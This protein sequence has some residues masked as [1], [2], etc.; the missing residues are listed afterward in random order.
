MPVRLME[1]KPRGRTPAQ[2]GDGFA[3][4]VCSNSLRGDDLSQ[5]VGLL[6]EEMRLLGSLIL[7]SADRSRVPAGGALAVD[8]DRFSNMVTSALRSHPMIDVRCSEVTSIPEGPCVLATGPLTGDAL[9]SDLARYV[10]GHLAYYDAIA[11]VVWAES[12]DDSLVFRAS[13]Y[14]KGGGDDYINCPMDEVQYRR[15]VADVL[16]AQKVNP[17]KFEEAKYFEGCLPLEVMAE[18]G[19]ET[20]A[21]GP[22]KPVGLTDPKTGRRPHAVVQLRQDNAQGTAH[23]LVGFQTRMTWPEQQRVFRTIPGLENAE[24]VRLGSVHRN[25]FV[26]GP[27]VLND[28]LALTS[29]PEVH[30]A[31]QITGV[32]G[33]VESAA[34]GLMVGR[35]LAA[36]AAAKPF[37]F[38]P[39]N[40]AHGALLS[41]VRRPSENYQPSNVVW[42]MFDELDEPLTFPKPDGRRLRKREKKRFARGIMA[43]RALRELRHWQDT[44]EAGEASSSQTEAVL[45]HASW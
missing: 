25:T 28:E 37:Q 43:K 32:E 18:R 20:L 9:A 19:V 23:N 4:L 34:C 11:P 39:R 12:I 30:L 45:T 26:H 2:K 17:H 5:A 3:E 15:F 36:K 8:R 14:G 1:Q 13:R 7:R 16:G 35:L 42:S 44:G 27:E 10:G 40:T 38:P 24:F 29:R 6:K 21:H 31:G 41:H 33:Y 22:M